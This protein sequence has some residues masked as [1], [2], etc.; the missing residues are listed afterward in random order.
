M[1]CL[2]TKEVYSR[3]E[4]INTS[5]KLAIQDEMQIHKLRYP[6]LNGLR[7][8]SIT[9][10]LFYHLNSRQH[11]F[12]GLAGY[13]ILAPLLDFLQD[14][15][16]GVNIFFVIS[17]FLITSLLLN[18][19][20]LT[21]TVSL[22]GFYTRRTLRIF[23]AYYFM[24]FVYLLLQMR[25]IINISARSW[26][27]SLTFTKYFNWDLDWVTSHTWSLSIEEHFYIFWPLIFLSGRKLRIWVI[28]AIIIIVPVIRYYVYFHPVSWINDLTIFT[29]ADA[30]ATGC[31]FAL[32]RVEI[33]KK[34][35]PHMKTLFFTSV[36]L[37]FALRYLP[38]LAARL[39]PGLFLIPHGSTF[40]TLANFSIGIIMMYS[41]FG[42]PGRWHK[43]LELRLINYLGL[44]S[45]SLYLWQQLF[46]S[47]SKTVWVT[48][49][50][51]N[52]VFILLMSLFSY[53]IIEKPFLKLKSKFSASRKV[54]SQKAKSANEE[55]T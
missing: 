15:Q 5:K 8:I 20:K 30:I 44:L 23:P 3:M 43:F 45:Y 41:V 42:T 47:S 9:L 12:G 11:I 51:Q 50:P 13:K 26:A 14:G 10:V 2:G 19:E 21:N 48:R 31:F 18:E 35:T 54:K 6:G 22:K 46:I 55:G 40:G 1:T 7:F 52:L 29:R 36:F 33:L 53:Y 34:I 39:M 24:L 37:L 17:G 4:I 25:G 16:L 38:A 27:S 28:S 32:F 49:F